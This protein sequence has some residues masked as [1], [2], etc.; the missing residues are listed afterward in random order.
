MVC[1]EY[2]SYFTWLELRYL[3]KVGDSEDGKVD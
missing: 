3:E 1:Q 2:A